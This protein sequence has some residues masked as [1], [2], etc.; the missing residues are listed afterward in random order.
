VHKVSTTSPS[1]DY[2][3]VR[4]T[5]RRLRVHPNTVRNWAAQGLLR[6]TRLPGSRYRRFHIKEVERVARQ[7]EERKRPT[8][9]VPPSART[10]LVDATHLHAWGSRRE[11]QADLPMVVRRLLSAT[12]GVSDLALPAGEGVASPGW[13]GRVTC[14]RE[15]PYVPLGR[16]YWE[17]GAGQRPGTKA[18]ADYQKRTDAPGEAEPSETTFVF[19]TPRR[20]RNARKWEAARRAEGIW[21]DVRVIDADDL[22]GWLETVPGVHFWLS[23]RFGLHPR[24]ARSLEEWWSRFAARTSPVLPTALPLAGRDQ[25]ATELRSFLREPAAAKGIQATS[26][27]EAL[28][29]V[30]VALA[31]GEPG[32]GSADHPR[33]V[34][35][36]SE[37]WDRLV[38]TGSPSVL[39][40]WFDGAD[41]TRAVEAGHHVIVPLGAGDLAR[42]DVLELPRLGRSEA[43]DALQCDEISFER[44]DSLAALGRRSFKSLLRSLASDPRLEQPTWVQSDHADV[45]AP[46]VLVTK[47]SIGD[48]DRSAIAVLAG[49]E[50]REI[51]RALRGLSARDDPPYASAGGEWRLTSPEEAFEI[52]QHRLTADDLVRFRD[53]AGRVLAETDPALDLPAD[54]RQVASLRGVGRE[55]SGTLR[56]GVAEGLALLGTVGDRLLVDGRT[57]VE[58]AR[59]IVR[60]L[61]ARAN[62]D[63]TGLT[64]RSLS[65]ELSLLAEAAPREFLDAVETGTDGDP[66]LLR[67]MF[68]DSEDGSWLTSSSPHTGLLWALE[69]LCWSPDELPRAALALARLAEIDPG[70]RLTNRS[71]RSLRTVLLPWIPRTQARLMRRIE[72]IDLLRERH[73]AI[74]WELMLSLLPRHH[75]TSSQ[76]STPRF[77]DWTRERKGVP[78]SE[79]V[80][81]IAALVERA[82]KDAGDDPERL[83]QLATHLAPLPAAQRDLVLNRLES[84]EPEGLEPG[85]RLSLWNDVA[86]LVA[87]HREFPNAEW[88]MDDEPLR[89]LQGIAERLEPL[90]AVERHARLFDWRP[91]LGPEYRDNHAA[92]DA[93]LAAARADALRETLASR[94]IEGVTALADASKVPGQLGWTMAEVAGEEVRT[95]LLPLLEHEGKA[96]QL[97]SG[98]ARRMALLDGDRWIDDVTRNFEEWPADRQLQFLLAIPTGAATWKLLNRAGR[99]VT[100]R[101]WCSVTPIGVY[102]ADLELTV[103]TLLAHDRAWAAMDLLTSRCRR[104]DGEEPPPAPEL[105]EEVLQAGLRTEN[106]DDVRSGVTGYEVGVLLDFLEEAGA[107]AQTLGRLEWAYYPVLD[108]TRQPRAL[109][110]ALDESPELFVELVKLV[111][112]G[113]ND[114]PRQLDEQSHHVATHAWSVLHDWRRV[115]GLREDNRIDEQ[116]L[117]AWVR[118]ARLMLADAGRGDIGDEQVGQLLSGSPPGRDSVW[119][120][121]PVRELIEDLGST[122]LEQG[123]QVGRLNSRGVTTRGV[124]DGGRQERALAAQYADWAERVERWPRTSRLLREL[125]E[126][127]KRDAR[128][129]DER[130]SRDADDG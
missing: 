26:R 13:D 38:A 109:Q 20:W 100:G 76:T 94:S 42:G 121:E 72:T 55:F 67:T 4:D 35:Y 73:P 120:A 51:E 83:G 71:P 126:D 112:R 34:I 88:S 95:Q 113:D 117:R 50:W 52:L 105:V 7:M 61:L 91:D 77:R 90:D 130:A 118:Q 79:W 58:Y 75:D 114:E 37:V 32:G 19:V 3:S 128:M 102:G 30:A 107:D 28:A 53:L 29:F 14:S 31:A 111:Y 129:E 74:A 119:P 70:G 81:A 65:G 103:R 47:W 87:H 104:D 89:R 49:S 45:L 39:V 86:K 57:G 36:D 97:A 9:P 92:Y 63:A 68:R 110:A 43:R 69:R 21:Q 108:D 66:P 25:A 22:A 82:V 124:Y 17:I 41:V 48:A 116:H 101:Y 93:A 12:S 123:L 40:P 16:S 64:W 122:H 46:L 54:E 56:E 18:Q 84:V 23:E 44:A 115:P 8:P 1:S 15:H 125:A 80:D 99:E 6:A 59:M 62:A 10:E 5:A 11:A 127:Y 96:L 60:D 24:Q 85:G 27:E 78:V 98:W 106:V 33:V 2:L